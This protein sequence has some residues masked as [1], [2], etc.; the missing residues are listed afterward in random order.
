[1]RG[2]LKFTLRKSTKKNNN[3]G[4]IILNYNFG[5]ERK[6]RSSTKL[7]IYDISDWDKERGRL[8]IVDEDC[9]TFYELINKD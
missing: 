4:F 6:V 7:K 2:T 5:A 3:S 9:K 1:M 8:N